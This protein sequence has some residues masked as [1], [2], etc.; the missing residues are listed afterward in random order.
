MLW[1]TTQLAAWDHNM[2]FKEPGRLLHQQ[3][4]TVGGN[5]MQPAQS[6]P[7][8]L[9]PAQDAPAMLMG[10]YCTGPSSLAS[11]T[12]TTHAEVCQ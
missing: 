1:G 12:T 5:P 3:Q 11:R 8:S 6:L 9:Q 2:A 4:G 7:L 10:H